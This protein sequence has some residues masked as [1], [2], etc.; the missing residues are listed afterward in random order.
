[1]ATNTSPQFAADRINYIEKKVLPLTRRQLCAY[2]FATPATLPKG[3]GTTYTATRYNR[4]TVPFAPLSEG[5]PPVGETMTI[6]QVS[7]VCQQW[8]DKVTVTDVAEMTIFH[9]VF[10][11]AIRLTALQIAESDERNTYLTLMGGTQV[12]YVNQRGSRAALVAGDVLDVHTVNRTVAALMTIGAPRFNGD[13]E[14]DMQVDVKSGGSKAS[15]NPRTHAHYVSI[16]HPLVAADFRENPTVQT[17]WSYSDI[18]RLYNFEIGEWSSLTFCASNMV[19]FFTGI[20]TVSG[21]AGT[22]GGTL[23]AGTTYY[24]QV[25]GSDGQKQYESQIYQVDGGTAPGGSNNALT[26]TLPSTTGYTYSVY[27]GTSATAIQNLANTSSTAAP[28]SGPYTGVATQLPPG[29]VVVLT[30]IGPQQVPPPAPATGQTVFPTFVF[31]R[32][33]YSMIT[34]DS[35]KMTYLDA[36][37]KSD[38]LNQLRVVGWKKFY[39]VLITNQQFGCRIEST[40]NFTATFG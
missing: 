11:Q 36:A 31:G 2:Q 37:D 26:L 39:G 21:A 6:S 13:D 17:A 14:T 5:V 15:E 35:I 19:P 25:T 23:T 34:L 12:N 38:P 4:L 3:M 30:S 28:Q 33:Y 40:S 32:D 1:M 9:P 24:T 29:T 8:G 18:N 10:Q 27:I 16:I 20:A 22:T 7:G